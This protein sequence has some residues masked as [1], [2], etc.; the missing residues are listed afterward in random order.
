ML[1]Q[2]KLMKGAKINDDFITKFL[3]QQILLHF[4]AFAGLTAISLSSDLAG[5]NLRK[6]DDLRITE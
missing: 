2:S 6:N 5:W 1:F 4:A 3:H